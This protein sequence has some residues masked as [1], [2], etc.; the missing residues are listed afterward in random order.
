MNLKPPECEGCPLYAMGGRFVPP[1]GSCS[2]GTLLMGEA[3][4]REENDAGAPFVGPSGRLLNH[5]LSKARL[6]RENFALCNVIQCR[7]PNNEL[8]GAV[9]ETAAINH[10]KVHRDAIIARFQPKFIIALGDVAL[11]TL[12]G[13]TGISDKRG[14]EYQSTYG[15]PT[16]GTFHPAFLIRE[17]AKAK[18]A[19]GGRGGMFLAQ[20]VLF[21]LKVAPT[22]MPETPSLRPFI[23]ASDFRDYADLAEK[24]EWVAADIETPYNLSETNIILRIS[25]SI[26]THEAVSVPWVEPFAGISKQI[27][28]ASNDKLFW[29][30]DFDV[31]RL[32]AN[33]C[34]IGGRIVDVMWL[35]HFLFPD[36]PRGLGN[37]APFYVNVP[38]WKSQSQAQPEYY[39]TMDSY[40]TG[41]VYEGLRIH[42]RKRKMLQI[43]DRHVTQ[44]LQVLRRM[45]RRGVSMDTLELKSFQTELTAQ[46]AQLQ[47]K[48]N[49]LQ[50]EELKAFHP[51]SGYKRTPKATEG[52]IQKEFDGQTRWC[53]S[54]PF[55]AGSP[56]QIRAYATFWQHTLTDSKKLLSSTEEKYI[57]ILMNRYRDPIYQTILEYREVGKILSTYVNWPIGA[58]GKVHTKFTLAPA[59]QRL[60]SIHPNVQNIPASE[61]DPLAMRFRRVI[62]ASPGCKLVRADYRGIEAVL[63]GYFA[64]DV[65]YQHLALLGVHAFVTAKWLE[66]MI[67]PLDSP[68][69]VPFLRQ[70]KETHNSLYK[71]LRRA[72]HGINYGLGPEKLFSV[73]PGMF[74]NRKEAK[75]LHAFI[76]SLFKGVTDW[77]NRTVIQALAQNHLVNPFGY[78][79]WFW[80]VNEDGPAAIAQLPQ[81]T[82]A[83]IIKEAMLTLD[84]DPLCGSYMVWQIH[85]EL[86][87]DTPEALVEPLT[88]RVREVMERPIPELGGLVINVAIKVGDNLA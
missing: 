52:L 68:E 8:T 77:Q 14:Y 27:L 57:Q 26:S 63:T 15:I 18:A 31:P 47:T 6:E 7:P 61:D 29:N 83:A 50:P 65:E 75:Q 54:L 55:L 21:D 12:T 59:T 58:D 22:R 42:L 36:L 56:K 35:F 67:P 69:I 4:G 76:K 44:L 25:F 39:S 3:P 66:L 79:R 43:A 71:K 87:F 53:K 11:R 41:K 86:V 30:F 1:T 23:H 73:N 13:Q 70:V 78:I 62:K 16:V 48:L 2:N 37:V 60:S 10:C 80:D 34:V 24:S 40:V 33:G 88:S 82:A 45:E 32:E 46:L 51:A 64:G 49:A 28:A 20:A 84:A 85:D 38:E 5:L 19:A 17:R 72:V 81:S 74:E 9:Y